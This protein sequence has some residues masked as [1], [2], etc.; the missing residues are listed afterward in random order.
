[1]GSSAV[2]L[3]LLSHSSCWERHPGDFCVTAETLQTECMLKFS[4]KNRSSAASCLFSSP[5]C[6]CRTGVIRQGGHRCSR[7]TATFWKGNKI[8]ALVAC[9]LFRNAVVFIQ[10]MRALSL[11]LLTKFL[12][13]L[14]IFSLSTNL[15]CF[16]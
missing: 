2:L 15:P 9:P 11:S 13:Q 5:L 14:I 12:S 1:M 10:C 8:T 7:A 16:I 4:P 6:R 3:P